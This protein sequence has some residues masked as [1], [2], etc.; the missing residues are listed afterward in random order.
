MHRFLES[1][2]SDGGRIAEVVRSGPL[3]AEVP[4]CP[5]WTLAD[6]AR[7]MGHIHRWVTL[8]VVTCRRPQDEEI[9]APPVAGEALAEWIEAGVDSLVGAL[10][11]READ[12]P[13]WHPFSAPLVAA[14]WPRRQA[15]ET[16]I[17]RW[18]AESAVGVPRP[19][20]PAL[21]ADGIL[22]FFQLIVPRVVSRDGRVAPR[23]VLRIECGDVGLVCTVSSASAVDV[24]LGDGVGAT[25][26]ATV[27]GDACDVLLALW[28]R[29]TLPGV[30]ADLA[31]DW[32]RFGGN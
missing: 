21:A 20:D 27:R 3:D 26:D 9:A 28:K 17:H 25:P 12:A 11:E 29:I 31:R 19:L 22:E 13:T 8:A 6:L 7:H 18:D 1:V 5:E 4:S 14:V 24:A 16:M 23:G 32:L 15:Q 10:G 30:A 2:R